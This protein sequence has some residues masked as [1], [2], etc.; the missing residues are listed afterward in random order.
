MSSEHRQ[1]QAFEATLRDNG[2]RVGQALTFQGPTLDT[3]LDEV[4]KLGADLLILGSH[5]HGALYRFWYGDTASS[6]A[7]DPPCALLVVPV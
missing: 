1:T 6:I 5:R 7:H 2:V 4:R 3:I